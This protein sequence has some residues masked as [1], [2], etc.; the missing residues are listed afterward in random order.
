MVDGGQ[1]GLPIHP[2]YRTIL[3]IDVEGYGRRDRNDPERVWI[4]HWLFDCCADLLVEAGAGP[5][6]YSQSDT[7]DGLVLSID[8]HVARDLLLGTI[9][10]ELPSRLAAGGVHPGT[11]GRIR[12]R[13]AVHAGEVLADPD[14]GHGATVV[15]ACRLLDAEPVRTCLRATEAPL[16]AIVSETIYENIVKHGYPPLD[17]AT[18]HP[19]L[20]ASKEGPMVGWVHVPGDQDAVRRAGLATAPGGTQS[21]LHAGGTRWPAR[22]VPRELPGG[23]PE[24]VGRQFELDQLCALL[25]SGRSWQEL[26]AVVI[27]A[28]DGVGGV[29]KTALA[30]HAARRMADRF[31]DGQLYVD[32]CGWT[33]GVVPL[34]PL[35]VLGRFMRSLGMDGWQ[36]PTS[37][38][39][40]AARYRSL[41]ADRR[42]LIML[43]NARN[44]NQVRPLLP[45]YSNCVV[46]VTSRDL[47]ADLEGATRLPIDVLPHDDAIE[48]LARLVGRER[49]EA[50]PTATAQV[51]RACGGLPLALRVAAAWL[52]VRPGWQVSALADRLADIRQR[53]DRLRLGDLAVR[54]LFEASYQSLAAEHP[55]AA[56]AFRLLGLLDCPDFAASTSAVML[57]QPL[58]MVEALLDRLVSIHLLETPTPGRYQFHDLLRLLAK[59]HALR[60]DDESEQAGAL[61]RVFGF[62]LATARRTFERIR[63]GDPLPPASPHERQYGLEFSGLDTMLAWL[64]AERANLV[65]LVNQV[66]ATSTAPPGLVGGITEAMSAFLEQRGYLESWQQASGTAL[67]TA[68]RDGDRHG[69]ANALGGIG[70]VLRLKGHFEEAIVRY[71]QALS[72]YQTIGDQRGV[73]R[74]LN[75]LGH[76]NRLHGRFPQAIDF[77]E[78]ALGLAQTTGNHDGEANALNNLGHIHQAHGRFEQAT[79]CHQQA[80]VIY[81]A[82]DDLYGEANALN[83][84]GD[85]QQL[86]G[87][88]EEAT[89]YYR[90][91]LAQHRA[92]RNRCGEADDL[93]ALGDVH[94]HQGLLEQALTY[95]EQAIA[96]FQAVNDPRG[97]AIVVNR[98]GEVL[99]QQGR[100]VDAVAHHERSLAILDNGGWRPDQAETLWCLGTTLH[101]L[102]RYDEARQRWHQAFAIFSELALPEA[103]KVRTRL[104]QDSA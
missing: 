17:P 48:L 94:R 68:R 87:Q 15:Q 60:D 28:I 97:E 49:V 70:D 71:Q 19:V 88:F 5:D 11:G 23:I 14:P 82:L 38:E 6:D 66:A 42:L 90:Q 36:I 45:G 22:I 72:L 35:E 85:A 104:D 26:G 84:L 98:L 101:R 80:L 69:E 18:W 81:Q 102:G 46:L 44:A 93:S 12:V 83:N 33:P 55:Q 76:L 100:L 25:D 47:L 27:T 53:L 37:L 32:L 79:T 30:I 89:A 63:P 56:R 34:A 95:Y 3:A 78:Q 86:Q 43:D 52:A 103:R 7:G 8:P 13:I 1:A 57:A 50:E 74:T 58:T 39:E 2:I 54:T 31:P 64:E 91:S 21:W 41:L 73:V 59:D 62:Y 61:N 20:V 24:F 9:L 99:Q 16:V 92:I 67:A 51:V 40:A 96:L 65:V 4:R 29:G 77:Y 10:R 75:N